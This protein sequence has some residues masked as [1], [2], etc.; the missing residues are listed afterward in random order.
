MD[1]G[2]V[3][4]LR[5]Q[6]QRQ[7]CATGIAH[8]FELP[9]AIALLQLVQR[10]TEAGD[11]LLRK[12]PISPESRLA[13]RCHDELAGPRQVGIRRRIVYRQPRHQQV[14]WARIHAG[15]RGGGPG[16]TIAFQ[17]DA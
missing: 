4:P 8:Q 2:D 14:M 10:P 1:Q 13:G 17:V 5:R 7:C 11:H 3:I 9:I 6:Q 16:M 15:L 12:A